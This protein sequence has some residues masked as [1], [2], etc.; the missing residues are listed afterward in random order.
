MCT[1]VYSYSSIYFKTCITFYI[2]SGMCFNPIGVVHGFVGISVVVLWVSTWGCAVGIGVVVLWFMVIGVGQF[3]WF[4]LSCAVLWF[5]IWFDCFAL[6]FVCLFCFVFFFFFWF[7]F[8]LFFFCFL[9]FFFFFVWLVVVGWEVEEE[10][11]WGLDFFFLPSRCC[12][13]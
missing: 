4:F 10:G 2:N 8:V 13:L 9:V 3:I 7:R 11:Y 6:F 12:G 5:I 1:F